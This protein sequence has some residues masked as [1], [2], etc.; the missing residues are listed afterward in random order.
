MRRRVLV[1]LGVG[2]LVLAALGAAAVSGPS[3][4]E[5]G[6][7]PPADR[8]VQ[9]DGTDSAVWPYTSRRRS[10]TGRTLALNV[11]VRG[12]P[13]RVR[14]LFLDETGPNWTRGQGDHGVVPSL[15]RE[16]GGAARFSY[17]TP[18]PNV[19]GEWVPAAYQ[20]HVG[21]YFGER[22]H[23]RAYPSLEGDWTGLQAHTEYWDWF[24]LRHTV[25]GLAPAASFVERDLD[26]R[27]TVTDV[28]RQHHG[29]SGGRS[30]G[31]LTVIGVGAAGLVASTGA[32][33]RRRL[34]LELLALPAAVVGIVL[35]VRAG[36]LAIEFLVPGLP[37]KLLAALGYPI[38]AVGPLAVVW[39]LAPPRRAL[40]AAAA[41]GI[42]LAVALT[43]DFAVVGVTEV[44][45]RLLYHR[46][47]LVGILALVTLGV[48]TDDRRLLL[49]GVL[50]WG[51]ALTGVLLGVL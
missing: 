17:V 25:T 11:V 26:G 47:A 15:W 43:A 9:P 36:G 6:G 16:A 50:G 28:H 2:V 20:L 12:D 33:S 7:A 22:V 45:P 13:E 37:P 1:G 29:L 41:T 19:A 30:S 40:P 32:V 46:A 31:W 27:R 8:L 42:G 44:P 51:V 21:A 14:S 38:L 34:P 48:A 23:V 24:R 18:A 10:V 4:P 5:T 49:P 35:G 39:R 3:A